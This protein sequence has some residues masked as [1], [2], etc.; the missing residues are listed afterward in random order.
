[1]TCGLFVVSVWMARCPQLVAFTPEPSA[2]AATLAA[3]H[4][5]SV[6][7]TL[8]SANTDCTGACVPVHAARGNAKILHTSQIVTAAQRSSVASATPDAGQP[9]AV[10]A[11]ATV[12]GML[13]G[14][15]SSGDMLRGNRQS[16]PAA[17]RES[18]QQWI[19]MTAY[20]QVQTTGTR[21]QVIADYDV[22]AVS[23]DRPAN[24][25][26]SVDDKQKSPVPEHSATQ[27]TI[28]RMIFRILPASSFIS[29]PDVASM[30]DGW[31][32]LQL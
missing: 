3:L 23:T 5:P 2:Q 24:G 32:V 27:I 15:M 22:A 11:K 28:T 21:A 10:M 31:L 17:L 6:A 9:R 7:G 25:S 4:E 13:I 1:L 18:R 29:Q 12:G 30:R 20:E 8:R 14:D 26:A 16:S 19:V